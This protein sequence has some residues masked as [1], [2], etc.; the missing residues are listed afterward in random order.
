MSILNTTTSTTRPTLGSSDIGKSYL[1]TDSNK[2]L[3]WD[4]GG[5]NEWNNDAIIYPAISNS[6]SGSFDGSGDWIDCNPITVYQGATQ[7]SIG[8]WYKSNSAGLGPTLGSRASTSD[9]W[10]FLTSAGTNYIVIRTAGG[11]EIASFTA[12]NDTNFHHYI[13][14]YS[15][16]TLALY[17]DGASET[18]LSGTADSVLHSQTADFEIGRFTSSFYANG[19]FDEVA[20]WSVTLDSNNVSQLYNNGVPINL[21][22][23]AG[24]YNQSSNLTHWWRIGD[25]ASDTSSGGGAVAAGN[26]IGNVENAAN[27]GTNDGTGTAA[28]YSSTTP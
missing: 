6:F 23:D 26:V 22:S 9:Q 2:I 8:F 1:E 14:T 17:I 5:W 24:N 11:S 15:A 10:G 25:H 18:S 12:P 13:L 4:G 16:G 20:L 28:T 21:S 19:L 27:P 3:V 7:L